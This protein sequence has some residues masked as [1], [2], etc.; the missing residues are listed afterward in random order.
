M[1]DRSQTRIVR[2]NAL[3]THTLPDG[4]DFSVV[5]APFTARFILCT[6]TAKAKA[7]GINAP[8][9][10][11]A[12]SEGDRAAL[13]LG[14]DETLLL[15]SDHAP[16][17]LSAALTARLA[18]TPHSLVDVSHRQLGLE[19]RGPLAARCL[20]AG[21]PLDLRLKSF[22]VGMVA[23]TIFLKAEIVLW[24]RAVERFQ[25]EVWR[26]FMPYLIG[27]L[28]EAFAGVPENE[29]LFDGKLLPP[30]ASGRKVS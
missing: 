23:R 13:W 30:G 19:L 17:A 9:V 11:R 7:F 29:S 10:L 25:V 20:N 22:P 27:H 2:D 15:A 3:A 5:S 4:A 21:C 18:G 1:S 16:G 26:S 28:N 6:A 12:T 8:G 24:R 14:P